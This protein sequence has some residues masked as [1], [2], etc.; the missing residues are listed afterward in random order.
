MPYCTIKPYTPNYLFIVISAKASNT[1]YN[2]S[3]FLKNIPAL[4]FFLLFH[5]IFAF[6]YEISNIS[7]NYGHYF[8]TVFFWNNHQ[9][10]C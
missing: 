10:T 8:Q 4:L 2:L 3:F 6:I 1:V 9:Q 7:C 5:Q